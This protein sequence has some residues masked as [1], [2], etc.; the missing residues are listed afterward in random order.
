MCISFQITLDPI[1]W[2][3]FGLRA[4]VKIQDTEIALLCDLPAYDRD[5][6]FR[7]VQNKLFEHAALKTLRSRPGLR[8]VIWSPVQVI[9]P[10]AF[11]SLWVI[12]LETNERIPI[13]ECM[14]DGQRTYAPFQ[15]ENDQQ[16]P[17]ALLFGPATAGEYAVGEVITIKEHGNNS[18]GTIIY[19]I[20]PD[21]YRS[22]KK[23]VPRRYHTVSGK[24]YTDSE[25][26]RYVVDC[27]DGFPHI[28][29]QSQITR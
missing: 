4:P 18:T 19:I 9:Q 26:A 5:D 24:S 1:D 3:Q 8:A 16:E 29:H 14:R 12:T 13:I 15:M 20:P 23:Q 6:L 10:Q 2:Q 11:L 25:A 27:Q 7:Q 28:V 17:L 21:E 22:P